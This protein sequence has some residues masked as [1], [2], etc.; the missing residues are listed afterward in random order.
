MTTSIDV[1]VEFAKQHPVV[2]GVF[3]YKGLHSTVYTYELITPTFDFGLATELAAFTQKL[4]V[5]R[6]CQAEVLMRPGDVD[7]MR[8]LKYEEVWVRRAD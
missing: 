4:L 5:K 8:E 7:T 2:Q 6:R 3:R 1:I